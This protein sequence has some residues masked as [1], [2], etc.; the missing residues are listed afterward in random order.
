MVWFALHTIPYRTI[1]ITAL[2][3]DEDSS[4]G[5]RVAAE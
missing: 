1:P 3:W 2:H 4:Y 5:L